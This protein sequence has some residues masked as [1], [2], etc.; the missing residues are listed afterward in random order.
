M[1]FFSVKIH[2]FRG[3]NFCAKKLLIFWLAQGKQN[4]HQFSGLF[5]VSK[6]TTNFFDF[7]KVSTQPSKKQ[8]S[9]HFLKHNTTMSK[10]NYSESDSNSDFGSN[11]VSDSNSDSDSDSDCI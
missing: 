4:D 10:N 5:K 9:M 7:L 2:V 1:L 3:K 6:I 11:S 8:P